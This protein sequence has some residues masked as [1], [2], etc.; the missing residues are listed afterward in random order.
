MRIQSF[1]VPA[2]KGEN[3]PTTWPR[4][5]PHALP[6]GQVVGVPQVEIAHG[7]R[8]SRGQPWPAAE[9]AAA[10]EC[11]IN[12]DVAVAN[13]KIDGLFHGDCGAATFCG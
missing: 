5:I 8:D 6:V 12:D 7:M 2:T 3:G 10:D 1:P 13:N 9:L 4:Q 11:S